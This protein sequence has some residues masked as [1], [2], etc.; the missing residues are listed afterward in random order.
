VAVRAQLGRPVS[1]EVLKLM[2]EKRLTLPPCGNIGEIISPLSFSLRLRLKVCL[3]CYQS[4]AHH[5]LQTQTKRFWAGGGSGGSRARPLFMMLIVLADRLIFCWTELTTRA[6]QRRNN[7]TANN[8]D[9]TAELNNADVDRSDERAV[10]AK[11]RRSS[12]AVLYNRIVRSQEA[13]IEVKYMTQ[14]QQKVTTKTDENSQNML[15]F[16]HLP[17]NTANSG[18]HDE[19][20]SAH[21]HAEKWRWVS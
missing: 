2:E 6:R 9:T 4:N 8:N 13:P 3:E 1:D 12:M 19:Q 7:D 21:E 11:S 20:K 18:V 14:R 17:M 16:A 15:T 10:G 5:I